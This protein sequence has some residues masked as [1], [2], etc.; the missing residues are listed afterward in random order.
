MPVQD[1]V[2]SI[3]GGG[4]RV[5]I[6]ATLIAVYQRHRLVPAGLTIGRDASHARIATGTEL[7]G[8]NLMPIVPKPLHHG[9]VLFVRDVFVT[10]TLGIAK[11]LENSIVLRTP[12]PER[13]GHKVFQ[14]LMVALLEKVPKGRGQ[15][16][17]EFSEVV[18]P[19]DRLR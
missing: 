3:L 13:C 5:I 6:D 17:T 4:S 10:V 16:G 1:Y 7:A 11:K 2:H 19:P 9:V 18:M 12:T 14:F 8:R 15:H